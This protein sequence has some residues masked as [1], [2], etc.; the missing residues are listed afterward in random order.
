ME[1]FL[2]SKEVRGSMGNKRRSHIRPLT[3]TLALVRN[4]RGHLCDSWATS[5]LCIRTAQPGRPTT[6]GSP[7]GRELVLSIVGSQQSRRE[8]SLS[9]QRAVT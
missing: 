5:S 2:T 3:F 8:H 9:Y 1:F 7:E 6:K 4:F